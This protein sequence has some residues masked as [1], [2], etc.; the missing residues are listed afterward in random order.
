MAIRI[1]LA[2]AIK[3]LSH[4]TSSLADLQKSDN[5]HARHIETGFPILLMDKEGSSGWVAA[6]DLLEKI[7]PEPS[8]FPNGNCGMPIALSFWSDH[9]ATKTSLTG[10]FSPYAELISRQ[11]ADGRPYLQGDAPGLADIESY[12]A[13]MAAP[14]EDLPALVAS[15]RKRMTVLKNS[16]ESQALD[17]PEAEHH[18]QSVNDLTVS[19]IDLDR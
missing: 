8:L 4:N 15:W 10:N 12:I 3:G 9:A 2:L 5:S 14:E 11:I 19:T 6:L 13:V 18:L 7:A 1:S 16:V 17:T